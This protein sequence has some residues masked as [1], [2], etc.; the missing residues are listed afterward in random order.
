[1]TKTLISLALALVSLSASAQVTSISE[2]DY[3]KYNAASDTSVYWASGLSY[4]SSVG[5][6]DG[7]LQGVRANGSGYHDNLH[8]FEV[9]YTVP[10]LTL[11]KVAVLPR[12]GY[13]QMLNVDVPGTDGVGKYALGSVELNAP[14]RDRLNGYVSYSHM[15]GFT[16]AS[17]TSNNRLQAGVDIT[18][19]EKVSVRTGYSIVRQFGTTQQGLVGM[20]FCS[21]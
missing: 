1:M 14:I 3:H 6:F 20:V 7:Y 15:K 21:F 5:T 19:T 16:P 2:V 11:G 4:T 12:L 10:N 17:I 8:G 13:G 9:G 18:L